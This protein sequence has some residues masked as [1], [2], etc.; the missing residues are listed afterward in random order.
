MPQTDEKAQWVQ[1]LVVQAGRP[2]FNP[3]NLHKS[4]KGK[5]T[6]PNCYMTSHTYL[7]VC[8]LSN[9]S[10]NQYALGYIRYITGSCMLMTSSNNNVLSQ[11]PKAH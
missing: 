4:G 10:Y 7:H 6:L 2:E 11:R 1:V 5:L 3:W 9:N 8:M